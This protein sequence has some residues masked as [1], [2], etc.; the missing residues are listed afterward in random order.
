MQLGT[1]LGYFFRCAPHTEDVLRCSFFKRGP[2]SSYSG[3]LGV[4][5]ERSSC[6]PNPPLLWPIVL[7]LIEVGM[8]F[9]FPKRLP[10]FTSYC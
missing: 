5:G 8:C 3:L 4:F 1:T 6:E 10:N 7:R 9:D 2:S